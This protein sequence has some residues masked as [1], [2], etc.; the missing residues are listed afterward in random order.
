MKRGK[1]ELTNFNT[2]PPPLNK[3]RAGI[4]KAAFRVGD[5]VEVA[6]DLSVGIPGRNFYGGI[7]Y[8]TKVEGTGSNAIV[9]LN[10]TSTA[11]STWTES[12]IPL[13]RVKAGVLPFQ[14]MKI[15]PK[16]ATT[17]KPMDVESNQYTVNSKTPIIYAL[18]MNRK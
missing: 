6:E 10:Y 15:R 3:G 7:G 1:T 17:V 11:K 2:K 14:D 13:S 16:R 4:D 8:V 12:R 5:C 9:S 18:N